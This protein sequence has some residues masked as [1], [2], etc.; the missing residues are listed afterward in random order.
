MTAGFAQ[1]F[2]GSGADAALGVATMDMLQAN[3]RTT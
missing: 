1:S 3:W 2:A